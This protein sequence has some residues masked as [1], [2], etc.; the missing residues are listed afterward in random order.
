MV[1]IESNFQ[2][3]FIPDDDPGNNDDEILPAVFNHGLHEQSRYFGVL[4][5]IFPCHLPSR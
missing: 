2:L 4:E 1:I 3:I 5:S